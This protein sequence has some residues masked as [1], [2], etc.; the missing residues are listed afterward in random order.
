MYTFFI[1]F[2]NLNM[3]LIKTLDSF[4]QFEQYFLLEHL[5]NIKNIVK[6]SQTFIFFGSNY[7]SELSYDYFFQLFGRTFLR[8]IR[9]NT[10][11]FEN[12]FDY[13][14]YIYIFKTDFFR[15]LFSISMGI[16]LESML[17]K[18]QLH[19]LNLQTYLN[20]LF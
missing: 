18:G 15:I 14:Y 1:I 11:I 20:T 7:L 16:N 12:G 4:E 2:E 19:S 10:V 9:P 17:Y 13:Q 3:F 5:W 6:N 8:L